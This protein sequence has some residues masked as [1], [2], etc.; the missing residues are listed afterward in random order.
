[1]WV[2]SSSRFA[3]RLPGGPSSARSAVFMRAALRITTGNIESNPRSK[4]GT[5]H[6][7]FEAHVCRSCKHETNA[8]GRGSFGDTSRETRTNDAYM[9]QA[10]C[11]FS[12]MSRFSSVKNWNLPLLSGLKAVRARSLS[13]AQEAPPRRQINTLGRVCGGRGDQPILCRPSAELVQG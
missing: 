5:A 13:E 6:A 11:R 8:Q 4:S 7:P 1:M 2:R 9:S 10:E 12:E 3:A